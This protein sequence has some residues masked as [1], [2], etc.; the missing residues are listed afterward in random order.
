MHEV[1][2]VVNDVCL[3]VCLSRGSARLHRAKTAEQIKMLIG[4]NTLAGPWNI[5]LHGGQGILIPRSVGEG[6]HCSLCQIT[7]ASCYISADWCLFY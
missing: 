1:Q 3:S 2:T 4:V 5:V 6:F 7:L